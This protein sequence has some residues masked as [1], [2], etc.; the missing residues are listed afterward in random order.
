MGLG[1]GE[2]S[3]EVYVQHVKGPGFK[4]QHLKKNLRYYFNILLRY[5]KTLSYRIGNKE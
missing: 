5:F 1:E 4:P 2:I 3:D